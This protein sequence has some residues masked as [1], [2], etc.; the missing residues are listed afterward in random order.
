MLKLSGVLEPK[1]EQHLKMLKDQPS[2]N[3]LRWCCD[4]ILTS[5][6]VGLIIHQNPWPCSHGLCM[7]QRGKKK[8]Q[9][10]EWRATIH[11]KFQNKIKSQSNPFNEQLSW[12]TLQWNCW[13]SDVVPT[14]PIKPLYVTLL[15]PHIAEDFLIVHF[16][17]WFRVF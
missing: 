2:W 1:C 6:L 5:A 10:R 17:R 15:Q 4:N 16:A 13:R 8:N 9:P 3:F 12:K 11:I 7:K 14:E